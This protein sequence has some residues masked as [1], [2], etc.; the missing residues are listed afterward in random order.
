VTP[1]AFPEQNVVFAKD[2]PP[3]MP[4]PALRGPDRVISCWKLSWRERLRVLFT[5]RVWHVQLTF[6]R[7]PMPIKLSIDELFEEGVDI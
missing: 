6:G 2:Q 3:Y 7:A 4:L 5:G 1:I